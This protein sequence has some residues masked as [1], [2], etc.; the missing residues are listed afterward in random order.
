MG[1]TIQGR[2]IVQV[3]MNLTNYQETSMI[4]AFQA[5]RRKDGGG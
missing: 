3:S 4:D 1:V 5:V 2:D